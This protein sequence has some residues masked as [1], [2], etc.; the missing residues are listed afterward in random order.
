MSRMKPKMRE[1]IV[2][3]PTTPAART[4]REFSEPC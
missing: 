2:A 3:I 4:T 1:S